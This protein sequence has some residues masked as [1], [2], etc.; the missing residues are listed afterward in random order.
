MSKKDDLLRLLSDGK[1]HGN[2]ELAD[3]SFRFG[4]LLYSLRK[5]GYC[6]ETVR[7]QEVGGFSY[8]LVS[9]KREVK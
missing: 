1:P 8:R 4:A 2:D 5:E 9:A 6:I 7:E 3:I